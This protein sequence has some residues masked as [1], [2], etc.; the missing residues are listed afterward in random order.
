MGLQD[1]HMKL[2]TDTHALVFTEE[3]G[4]T[5][6]SENEIWINQELTSNFGSLKF[7]L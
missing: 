4:I 2:L 1:F 3:R 7:Y 5:A 6:T